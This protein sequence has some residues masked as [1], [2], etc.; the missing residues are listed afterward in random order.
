MLA[1]DSAAQALL[2]A[3]T[4][5]NLA[6]T[7]D[8]AAIWAEEGN[9][10]QIPAAKLLLAPGAGTNVNVFDGNRFP[11]VDIV[12]RLGWSQTQDFN[13]DVFIRAD[14]HPLDG[15][16][17]G[18]TLGTQIPP[19]P[20]ALIDDD[21][22]YLHVWVGSLRA[23]PLYFNDAPDQIGAFTPL[24]EQELQGEEG[25]FSTSNQR[26]DPANSGYFISTD[27][28]GE[29][30][31]GEDDVE[32]WSKR[33]NTDPIPAEKLTEAPA[34]GGGGAREELVV[35]Q[36]GDNA[37]DNFERDLE[38][39]DNGRTLEFLFRQES[40]GGGSISRKYSVAYVKVQTFR[41]VDLT[42]LT[43]GLVFRHFIDTNAV[44]RFGPDISNPDGQVRVDIDLYEFKV[45]L[46]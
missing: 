14:N 38:D 10:E 9:N 2:D 30:I 35:W 3:E 31:L 24:L 20:P 39:A 15:A 13:Q 11:A 18:F 41:E 25:A 19:F 7:K 46:I 5:L 36:D 40:T 8:D 21:S 1:A 16:A 45:T 12:L 37:T 32:D 27:V 29:L 4:A 6:E 28:P 44:A 42:D 33:G 23:G 34:G 22:L 17:Q 43:S 26:L